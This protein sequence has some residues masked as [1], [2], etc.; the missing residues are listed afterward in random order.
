MPRPKRGESE[1]SHH[2][3]CMSDAHMKKKYPDQK[4]RNAVCYSIY[5]KE[6]PR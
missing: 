6:K 2:K 4:Q 5:K 3:R 1:A